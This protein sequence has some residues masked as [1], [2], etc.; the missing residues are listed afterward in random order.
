MSLLMT[1]VSCEYVYSSMS[2]WIGSDQYL[3]YFNSPDSNLQGGVRY[4]SLLLCL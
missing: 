1:D 4:S 2:A 3:D